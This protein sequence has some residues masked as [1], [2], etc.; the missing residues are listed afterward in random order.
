MCP[1]PSLSH[2]LTTPLVKIE[3]DDALLTCVVQHQHNLTLMWKKY[4]RDK[5]GTKILTADTARVTSD[6]RISVIHEPGGQVY[7]LLIKNLTV[8]DAGVYICELNTQRITRSFHELKV[9]SDRLLAPGSSSDHTESPKEAQ[10]ATKNSID[11]W[12]YSTERPINHDFTD[13]CSAKNVSSSC[14]GFCDIKNILEGSTGSSPSQ[15]EADFPNIVSCMADGRD[16]MPCCLD[17]GI[18]QACSDLCRGEYTVQQDNIKSLFSCSAYTAPTLACIAV[19]VGNVP[20]INGGKG[21]W[22]LS[23]F[24]FF[25]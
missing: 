8:R 11:V 19:G 6:K 16:H 10:T 5:V 9:L 12:N 23:P 17:Q 1:V 15:C 3:G 24:F 4:S 25:F 14:L 2:S 20:S 7:V 21:I 18:P 13:C 22:S